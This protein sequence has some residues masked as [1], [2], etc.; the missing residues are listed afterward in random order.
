MPYTPEKVVELCNEFLREW[1]R[2]ENGPAHVVLSDWNFETE[3]IENCLHDIKTNKSCDG[4]STAELV[5]TG[6]FLR[7]LLD[8]PEAE[9]VF[10]HEPEY[11]TE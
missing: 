10:P 4:H 8:I 9:R 1:P 5:T 11:V 7:R 6:I 3:F 2:A